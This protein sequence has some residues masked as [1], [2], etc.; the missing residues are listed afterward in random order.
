ML[1]ASASVLILHLILQF[2]IALY[3]APAFMEGFRESV[4]VLRGFSV[5]PP[6]PSLA[7]AFATDHPPR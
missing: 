6:A 2:I 1:W 7:I 5:F 4:K 3:I